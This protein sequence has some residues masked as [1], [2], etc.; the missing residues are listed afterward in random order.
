MFRKF[1][2]KIKVCVCVCILGEG[3]VEMYNFLE[4]PKFETSENLKFNNLD[5]S[6]KSSCVILFVCRVN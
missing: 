4:T 5:E 2:K 3:V 6:S 1:L